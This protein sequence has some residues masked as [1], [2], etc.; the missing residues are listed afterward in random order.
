MKTTFRVLVIGGDI[1]S[2]GGIASF[3]KSLYTAYL[4]GG[5]DFTWKMFKTS[6]YKHASRINNG[7][8]FVCAFLKVF[9]L[10]LEYGHTNLNNS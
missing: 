7:L 2:N 6:D 8:T 3:I 5:K 9:F 1:T 4:Q 10:L